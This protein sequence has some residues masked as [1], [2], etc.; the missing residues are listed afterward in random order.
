[1]SDNSILNKAKYSEDTDEWYT[2]YNAVEYELSHYREQFY[3]KTVLCNC[4]DPYK[5]AFSNYF[6][7]YF[8]ILKLKKLICTSYKGSHI[9]EEFNLKDERRNKINKNSAYVLE[10]TEINDGK[11]EIVDDSVVF[12]Y[13][14]SKNCV[15]KIKGRWGF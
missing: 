1:M 14:K 13:L 12:T 9:V 4:D 5:S 3:G 11:D 15:K 6:L 2:D 8:N 7:K 10:A